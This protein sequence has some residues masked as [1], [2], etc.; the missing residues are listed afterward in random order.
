MVLTWLPVFTGPVARP[1]LVEGE[2]RKSGFNFVPNYMREPN[3]FDVVEEVAQHDGV[4][5]GEQDMVAKGG[6]V[7]Q[8]A[9]GVVLQ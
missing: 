1:S 3:A 7:P 8:K 6:V 2:I 5:N 4:G 9:K